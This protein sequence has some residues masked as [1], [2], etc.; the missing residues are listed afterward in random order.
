LSLRCREGFVVPGVAT[1]DTSRGTNALLKESAAVIERAQ[2]VIDAVL[3][4]LKQ[5]LRV[6]VQP[7][8]ETSVSVIIWAKRNSWCMMSW[9]TTRAQWTR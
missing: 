9:C 3:S 4:Q 1:H 5:E 2:G 8:R 6:R 7:S